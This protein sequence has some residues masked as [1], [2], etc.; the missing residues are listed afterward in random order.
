MRSF[1]FVAGFF[2]FLSGLYVMKF[3]HFG[4]WSGCAGLAIIILGGTLFRNAINFY[5]K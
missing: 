3:V 5:K 4:L 2:C 1:M